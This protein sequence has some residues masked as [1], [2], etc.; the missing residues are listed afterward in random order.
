MRQLLV[1]AD[2]DRDSSWKARREF[3]QRALQLRLTHA[4]HHQ[5]CGLCH[6]TRRDLRHHIEPLLVH[7]PAHDREKRCGVVHPKSEA[8]LQNR[9]VCL[10]QLEPRRIVALGKR[11]VGGG[12][13]RFDVDAIHDAD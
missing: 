10:L 7:E 4:K 12:I 3:P 1:V 5:L 13:P 11:S 2:H 9:P 8:A 6:E